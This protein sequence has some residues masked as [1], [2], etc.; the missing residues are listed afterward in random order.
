MVPTIKS[1]QYKKSMINP[2]QLKPSLEIQLPEVDHE[3]YLMK[4]V[5]QD[6]TTHKTSPF[7]PNKITPSKKEDKILK[8]TN[9]G[10]DLMALSH[11]K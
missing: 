7:V 3:A 2:T 9:S 4:Q 1:H 11:V 6:S 10:N 8:V 5:K